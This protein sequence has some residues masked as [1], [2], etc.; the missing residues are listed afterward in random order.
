MDG[1]C[2]CKKIQ[3]KEVKNQIFMYILNT[4]T[5]LSFPSKGY[6]RK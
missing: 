6:I 2:A 3:S 1:G 5:L 4:H